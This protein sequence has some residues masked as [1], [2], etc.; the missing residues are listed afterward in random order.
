[1]VMAVVISNCVASQHYVNP[2]EL[3]GGLELWSEL[4]R[5]EDERRAS[6]LHVCMQTM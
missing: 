3:T 4:V 5:N 1:M 2:S 6:L